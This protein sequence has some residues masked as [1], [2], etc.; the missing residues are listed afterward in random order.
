MKFTSIFSLIGATN[1]INLTAHNEP[2]VGM[3]LDDY[4]LHV[5]PYHDGNSTIPTNDNYKLLPPG[6]CPEDYGVISAAA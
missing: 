6:K 2:L 3:S 5:L 1:S 4:G